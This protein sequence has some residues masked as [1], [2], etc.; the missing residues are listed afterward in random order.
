M[1][2]AGR[3]GSLGLTIVTAILAGSPTQGGGC[4]RCGGSLAAPEQAVYEPEPTVLRTPS[5][6]SGRSRLLQ[7]QILR[8]AQQ[9]RRTTSIALGGTSAVCVRSCDG[10]FFPV[11]YVGDRDSLAK[12][13][14]ALCPNA[15]TQLYS[16]PLGGTI[17]EATSTTGSRYGDLAYAG[18][19][20]QALDMNCSCR[21]Q[22]QGWAEALADAEKRAQHH[23]GDILVTP[24]ISE[25]MSRPVPGPKAFAVA[26]ASNRGAVALAEKTGAP[27]LVLDTNGVD[28]DLNAATAVLSRATSGIG[29]EETGTVYYG[30]NQGQIMEQKGQDGSVKRVRIVAPTLY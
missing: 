19:F 12:I 18:K 7:R 10:G 27:P 24:E 5:A 25:K 13:C 20:E 28:L 11:P 1:C 3:F 21:R 9:G 30:L 29:V 6:Q 2:A 17:E 15:D 14:Q 8:D 16:M 26:D 23:A 4:G 22:G